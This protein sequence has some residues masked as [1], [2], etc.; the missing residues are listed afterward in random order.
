V[1]W[2]AAVNS[3]GV[4]LIAQ[5]PPSAAARPYMSGQQFRNTTIIDPES[6]PCESQIPLPPARPPARSS[7]TT[8]LTR[9]NAALPQQDRTEHRTRREPSRPAFLKRRAAA[10]YRALASIIPGRERLS[11]N[12][13][14]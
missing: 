11:W 1:S 4:P 5:L 8:E 13:S 12:L 9:R 7:S 14:F 6:L 3:L 2:L 10:R